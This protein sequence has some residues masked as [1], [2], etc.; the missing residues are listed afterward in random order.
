V[1]NKVAAP[2]AE[3][4]FDIMY[5]KGIS[6]AGSVLDSAIK[7]GL[8]DKRGSWLAFDGQQL[9]QGQDASRENLEKDPV[10]LEK[11]VTMVKEKIAVA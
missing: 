1:K 2:F 5:A 8:V 6:W 11:M 7:H 3:A 4:E 9:G 10:L